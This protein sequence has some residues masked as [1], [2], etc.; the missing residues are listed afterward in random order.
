[1]SKKHKKICMDLNYVEHLLNSDYVV[2]R[3]VSISAFVYL[4]GI[5]IS[6][7]SSAIG[8]ETFA[9]T[10]GVKKYKSIM[11]KKKKKNDLNSIASKVKYHKSLNFQGFNWLVY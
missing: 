10:V 6:I 3:Y 2:A 9:I 11:N 4:V 1:M 8:L 7:T 5:L